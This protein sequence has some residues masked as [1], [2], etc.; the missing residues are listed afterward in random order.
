MHVDLPEN[1]CWLTLAQIRALLNEPDFISDE[2]RSILSL[3]LTAALSAR[4][5]CER[6]PGVG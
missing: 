2:S 4:F 6:N 1:F 3:F 5:E